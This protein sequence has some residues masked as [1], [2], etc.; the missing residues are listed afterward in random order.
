VRLFANRED[1]DFNNVRDLKPLQVIENVVADF[2]GII[3]NPLLAARFPGVDLL[4]MH[5]RGT[6]DDLLQVGSI[7]FKGESRGLNKKVVEGIKYEIRA[8]LKDHTTT[9]SETTGNNNIM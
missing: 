8:Q 3:D 2:D 1:I 9:R 6:D 4:I 5:I 7:G